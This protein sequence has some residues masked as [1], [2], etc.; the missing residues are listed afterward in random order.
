M[1]LDMLVLAI[2]DLGRFSFIGLARGQVTDSDVSA[3]LITY[4]HL[5]YSFS[6]SV[7][8]SKAFS[9]LSL[10]I[11]RSNWFSLVEVAR[12]LVTNSDTSIPLSVSNSIV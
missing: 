2:L 1:I 5:K 7:V 11:M 6:S 10:A 4:V 12:G 8:L 9:M 3:P